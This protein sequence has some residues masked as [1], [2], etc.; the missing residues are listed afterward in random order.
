[1]SKIH[2]TATIDPSAEL[3]DGVEVGAYVVV[4]G[5]VKV[6]KGTILR[7]H[8]VIRR[9]TKMGAGNYVDSFACLGGEPQDLKFDPDTVSYLCIGDQNIFREGVTI[10]RATG[11]EAETKVG[12]NTYWMVNSHAGHNA[13]IQD[14]VI[15]TNGALVGG[16]ATLEKGVILAG[17]AAVHQFCWVGRKAMFQ[18]GARVSMHV[19]PYVICTGQNNV[20]SLNAVGLRRS[21]ELTAEDRQQIKKAFDLTYRSGRS[22]QQALEEMDRYTGW[23][24]AVG[25]FRKF[26]R[27][28][29][30]AK[31]PYKRG[32][33]PHLPRRS[34][35]LE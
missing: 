26:L 12:N 14:G 28:V 20:I 4:E 31:A 10:S 1:M 7:P 19:P 11:D 33:C 23:G 22:P 32:L 5:K 13:E 17:N 9:Y 21:E 15:L 27:Q 29:F 18:G 35:R 6:G 24:E 8:C 2:P 3:G 16:H 25:W 34:R 30:Q